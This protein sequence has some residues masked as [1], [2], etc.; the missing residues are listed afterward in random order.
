V[1]WLT[2]NNQV[3]GS[4]EHVQWR[5]A[6]FWI[7]FVL[8]GISPIEHDFPTRQQAVAMVERYCQ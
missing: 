4:I 8:D 7:A 6:D 5:G 3:C 2:Q 1:E